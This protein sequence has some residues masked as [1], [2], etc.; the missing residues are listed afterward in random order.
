MN[1]AAAK[2]TLAATRR[3][4]VTTTDQTDRT[5]PLTDLRV[6]E[7]GQLV[8]GPFC[9]Q[10][11][12]DMG[13]DVVKVEPPGTGD[14]L[15]AWG[16][17]DEPLWWSVCA[18]NKRCITLNLREPEGQ[19]IARRLIGDADIL[20]ENFRPGTL[21]RWG[22]DYERLSADNPGLIMVRVSGYGQTGPYA[23]RAGYASVGEAMGGMRH[24]CGEPDRPPSRAGLSL[25]DT[26]AAS[27]ACMG[28]L[29]ALHHRDL[30]GEGQMI[31][32]SIYESV[33]NVMEST[34][35]EYALSG[36]VRER[37]GSKLPK[38]APSNAYRCADGDVV[39]AANQDTVF[40]RLCDA[41]NRPDLAANPDYATHT[42]RGDHQDALDDIITE[43]AR[44]KTMAEIDA[45]M[46]QYGV[47]CGRIYRAPDMLSDPHFQARAAIVEV[48]H[49]QLG[50]LKMQD[51]FPRFSKTQSQVRWP[52]PALGAHTGDVLS[53]ELGI[54][55]D[56]IEALRRKKIV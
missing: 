50:R 48:D 19:E 15:R 40:K 13:A 10:L 44:A 5:G 25:G 39:I 2:R 32:A 33:L 21:E 12:A 53:G 31:D 38:V 47:P 54:S 49:P 45:L 27:Y 37:S 8:A 29:A 55:N 20:I 6:I 11:L 4:D 14:P 36:H 30:T 41:M 23:Q 35:S 52:G 42:A 7:L 16:R 28:A 24:L 1:A 43:W 3:P 56:A 46:E 9:G 18:R 34:I 51:A 22:L 26:L 17:S